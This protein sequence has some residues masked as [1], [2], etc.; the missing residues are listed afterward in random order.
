MLSDEALADVLD[1][2]RHTLPFASL[3]YVL[4]YIDEDALV[5]MLSRQQGVPGVALDRC[6]ID[7]AVLDGVPRELGL[8][9]NVLPVY[10]DEARVFVATDDPAAVGDVLREL[11]FIKGKTVVPHIALHVTLMRTVRACYAALARGEPLLC[12]PAADDEERYPFL[13]VVS[14]VPVSPSGEIEARAHEALVEDVTKE[15]LDVELVLIE[16]TETGLDDAS[17]GRYETSTVDVA[18]APEDAATGDQPELDMPS[19]DLVPAERGGRTIDLD[20]GDG[21]VYE[22]RADGPARILIVDDDFATRHLLVKELQPLGYLTA[23][24]SSGSEAVRAIKSHPPDLV[25]ID[26]MLPEVDGFQICRAIKQSRL[27]HHIP[28]ILMSAVIDSGRVTDELLRRYGAD[29]YFEKP[30]NT[31]RI[32]RRVQSLLSSRAASDE[33]VSEDEGFERALALYRTGQIEQAMELLRDGIR[34][35]P[36]SA[37][38]HFVLA[39]LLQKKSLI[40]EAIDEYEVTV[41]LK[42]DYFPAL[43]RLAYLYYKKGFSAKAIETWRRSLPYCPDPGLRQNIEVFMR[44]L[45]AD[46]Q[47]T[48]S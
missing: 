41:D 15:L 47:S 43:T 29:A 28:V 9:D 40:Y 36:L 27:Y 6:V 18:P 22:S 10:E 11:E 39:N 3:C 35:D 31:E 45:I 23:T 2:Q 30:L 19:V 1:C 13:A 32:R 25:V 7:L 46:M 5:R 44:K 33:V 21:A 16:S 34:V 24:A 4:G 42:P 20:E 14:D 48:Q 12:G 8:R 26:V 37:K 38:H 17:Q